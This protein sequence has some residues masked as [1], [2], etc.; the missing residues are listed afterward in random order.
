[1]EGATAQWLSLQMCHW[2]AKGERQNFTHAERV[3]HTEHSLGILSQRPLFPQLFKVLRK[4]LGKSVSF[5]LNWKKKLRNPKN[6]SN[7][8]S[9]DMKGIEHL[10]R[11]EHG[12]HLL[13][14][15]KKRLGSFFHVLHVL[16]TPQKRRIEKKPCFLPKFDIRELQILRLRSS[17]TED[18]ELL[19]GDQDRLPDFGPLS[20]PP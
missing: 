7:D 13:R 11:F 10:L 12:P 1:M 20:E 16:S 14:F 19:Q 18:F 5:C 6:E 17:L 4:C 15:R 8:V 2:S 9:F 3:I